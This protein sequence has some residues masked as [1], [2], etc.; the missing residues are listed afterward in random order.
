M[1]ETKIVWDNT[2]V[3]EWLFQCRCEMLWLLYSIGGTQRERAQ[4]KEMD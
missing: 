1:G 2:M 4:V 3:F